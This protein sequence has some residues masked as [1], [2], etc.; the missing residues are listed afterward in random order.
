[1]LVPGLGRKNINVFEQPFFIFCP[2]LV[3]LT[4]EIV[5]PIGVTHP[6][7]KENLATPFFFFQLK[8]FKFI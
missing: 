7:W 5:G 6:S 2:E 4:H 8:I 1:M 3:I